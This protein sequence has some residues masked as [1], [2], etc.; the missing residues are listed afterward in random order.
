MEL[1]EYTVHELIDK[2]ES[3]EITSYE[4]VKSYFDRIQ[5]KDGQVN[6]YISLMEEEALSK[7]KEVDEKRKKCEK[8]GKYAGIPIGIKDNM[9][10]KGTKTTCSSKMLENYVSPYDATVI[11]KLKEED[12]IFLG[13]T[14]MDEFAMGSSTEHSAFF[15]THNPW[16]LSTV[17]GGS[18][19]GS[20]AAVAS[21]MAPWALGS[22]TG[23]SV[24]QPSSLCG[25]VGLKPTYGLV[26]RYRISSICFFFRSNRPFNEGCYRFCFAFKYYCRT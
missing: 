24:R 26:S 1:Y 19:G 11:E 15:V 14:N 8:L 23:G 4:L 7:A 3:G 6:A 9:N 21:N 22:D 20:A 17:P 18:S 2:L 10:I 12:I 25:I 5:E 16:D 13:K